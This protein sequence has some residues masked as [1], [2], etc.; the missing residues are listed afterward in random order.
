MQ[1]IHPLPV[2]PHDSRLRV[3]P[4]ATDGELRE[5]LALPARLHGHDPS[6]IPPIAALQRRRTRAFLRAGD[7]VLLRAERDGRL[8]GTISALRDRGFERDQGERVV[9]FGYL[10]AEDDQRI[11]DALFDAAVAQARR[12]GGTHLRGPRDLTRWENVGLTVEGHEVPPPFLQGHHPAYYRARVEAAGLQKHHDLLAYDIPVVLPDGRPNQ[13]PQHVLDKAASI[14]VPGLVL[15][16]ASR[17]HLGRD[18]A[19]AHEVLNTAYRTVPE[20]APMSRAAFLS[21]G[22]PFLTVADP[23]LLQLATVDGRPVGFAACLPEL[24]EAVARTDGDLLPLGWARL[25]RGLRRVRTASFKLIGVVPELR[26]T[27]LH[28]AL[29]SA[30]VDGVRAAGYHRVDASVIDERN[31]PMRAVVEGIGMTVYRRYRFYD[32]TVG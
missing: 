20:T 15:R 12:W 1:D 3:R 9:W 17:L 22:R 18:L 24:N 26:G 25:L 11:V 21:V 19:L 13:L 5:A 28:A 8:V 6:W 30:V 14:D 32:R 7:L 23:R 31:G 27:G 29:I 16:P 10:A 2:Q 4:V